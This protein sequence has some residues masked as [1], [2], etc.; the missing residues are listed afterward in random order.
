MNKWQII[1]PVTAMLLIAIP[2]GIYGWIGH[3]HLERHILVSA[4][5]QQLDRHTTNIVQ[6]LSGMAVTDASLQ[7]DAI[8]QELQKIPSTSLISRSMVKVAATTNGHLECTVDTSSLGIP[9]RTIR[10]SD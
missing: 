3:V 5:T 10:D 2:A 9:P 4:V 7:D 8:F 1:C 6:I